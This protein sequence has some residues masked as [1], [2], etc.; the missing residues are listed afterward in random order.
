MSVNVAGDDIDRGIATRAAEL[1]LAFDRA[2]AAPTTLDRRSKDDLLRI[3]VGAQSC[4]IRLSEITGLHAGKKITPIPG[5]HNALRGIAGFRGAIL[6]VYDLQ[7]LLGHAGGDSPR[8]LVIAAA[9]PVAFAFEAFEG[10]LRVSRDAIV[11]RSSMPRSSRLEGWNYACEFV[12]TDNFV[13]PIVH[14]SSILDAIKG[15]SIKPLS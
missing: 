6:P 14:L 5:G 2:F 8:W 1:R 15:S 13:G 11:S 4:A 9:A 12:R 3:R 7:V 10:Q